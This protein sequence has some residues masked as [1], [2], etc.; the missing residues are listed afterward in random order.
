MLNQDLLLEC[1]PQWMSKFPYGCLFASNDFEDKYSELNFIA[2]VSFSK[3]L[4]SLS[5]ATSLKGEWL[6][7][8]L[9]YDYKNQLE[10]LSSSHSDNFNLNDTGFFIPDV[11][12]VSKKGRVEVVLGDENVLDEIVKSAIKSNDDLNIEFSPA[13]SREEYI[14][15]VRSLKDHLHRGDI[16]EINFCTEFKCDNAEINAG[17]LF[18]RVKK[19][20]SAPFSSFCKFDDVY[21]I[22]A[23]PER[24]FAIR[25]NK[26]ISQPIKGTIRRS[27]D[28]HED[29][30]L[31]STLLNDMKE[32]TENIMIV[33]LV[34]NDLSKVA[35]R[36]TV[37]AEEICR[38]YSFPHVHQLIST[39]T[40]TIKEGCI[41]ADV[42]N[43]TFPMGSMTGV[44]KVRAMQLSEKYEGIRRGLYSGSVGYVNPNGNCDFNVVIRSLIYNAAS[45]YL[46]I[47]AGG[48]ITVLSDEEKEYEE[49]LLKAEALI[50]ASGGQLVSLDNA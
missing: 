44:P 5:E 42:I 37:A 6:F 15:R 21:L 7:G 4:Y 30:R 32:R 3:K 41:W 12:I 20:S 19:S 2:A 34:R 24:Y 40:A 36:G 23:S 49:C 27:A 16:Y 50:K 9:C 48:A 1:L 35:K 28:L 46:S 26:I 13:L 47:M 18:T 22:S 8:F 14:R 25:N 10:D 39:V 11:L 38:L 31:R 33:D 29:D 43:S 17:Q 45:K